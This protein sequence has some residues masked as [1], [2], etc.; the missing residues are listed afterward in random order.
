EIDAVIPGLAR[1]ILL[2]G[3]QVTHGPVGVGIE[4][5]TYLA[6]HYHPPGARAAVG[7]FGHHHVVAPADYL[8]V[9]GGGAGTRIE[10]DLAVTM[11]KRILPFA[12]SGGAAAW[13]LAE[14]PATRSL[15]WLSGNDLAVLTEA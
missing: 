4:V 10:L 2:Q 11:R 3:W 1:V 6:D 14:S 15:A 13:F 7:T 5:T 9:I 12:R 8:L